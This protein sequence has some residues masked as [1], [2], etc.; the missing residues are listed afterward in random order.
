[1]KALPSHPKKKRL[2]DHYVPAIDE[3]DNASLDSLPISAR[4]LDSPSTL[5]SG[6]ARSVALNQTVIMPSYEEVDEAGLRLLFRK[7]AQ[8][9]K[10][11]GRLFRAVVSAYA[12]RKMLI[13]FAMHAVATLVVW[14]K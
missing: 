1:M 3:E 7:A 14:G 6:G 8:Y 2:P 4:C 13:V 9:L 5:W 11:D 12:E 10:A